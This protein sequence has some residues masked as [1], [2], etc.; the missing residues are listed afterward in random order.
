MK[1]AAFALNK[2]VIREGYFLTSF[3]A[4]DKNSGVASTLKGIQ[5]LFERDRFQF[6]FA[7]YVY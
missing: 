4:S 3:L 6:A 5:Q 7:S 2:T 1:I